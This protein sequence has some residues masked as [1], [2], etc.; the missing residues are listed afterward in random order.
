[1]TTFQVYISNPCSPSGLG[2]TI[3]V[4]LEDNFEDGSWIVIRDVNGQDLIGIELHHGEVVAGH[5]PDGAEWV[6]KIHTPSISPTFEEIN[7]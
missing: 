4:D 2:K 3:D 6:D 5:W 7:A 1:M